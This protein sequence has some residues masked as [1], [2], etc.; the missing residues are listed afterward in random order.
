MGLKEVERQMGLKEPQDPRRPAHA[1]GGGGAENAGG[2]G[3]GAGAAHLFGGADMGGGV[4]V[5]LGMI[6]GGGGGDV[7]RS[8]AP[9]IQGPHFTCFTSTIVQI[10]TEEVGR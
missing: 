4:G 3:W 1:G 7:E 10:V 2:G 6:G 8:R 5:G 9:G